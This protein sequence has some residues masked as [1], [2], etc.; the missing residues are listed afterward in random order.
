MIDTQV[1][2]KAR[3]AFFTPSEISVYLTQW[4]IRRP[5][6]VILEPSCGEAC[7]LLNAGDQLKRLGANAGAWRRQLH[8]I[9]IHKRSAETA[10]RI[11]TEHQFAATITVRNFFDV[12]PTA[13]Y[14]AIIGNPPYVRYQN[15]AGEA[16][17]KALEAALTQGV[18]LTGLTSSWAPFVVHASRFLKPTGRLALVLPA[19]LLAVNYAAQVRR[20]LLDRFSS[21]RLVL[22]ENRVFPGVLEEVVLLL[23]E[24]SGGA[25]NFEVYQARNLDDLSSTTAPAWTDYSPEGGDKWTPALLPSFA[26]GVYRKLTSGNSFADLL[27]WGETS[28]GS[29]T[30]NNEFFA[31]TRAEAT[32]LG[33]AEKELL[34]ISPPGSRHLKGLKFSDAG[35]EALAKD[36]ASCYLFHPSVDKPSS[37]AR[38]YISLGE[39]RGVQNAYKCENRTPWWRVPIVSVP[40]LLFTYMNHERPRLVTNEAGVRIINSVYGVSLKHTKKRLGRELLPISSLNSVT[41]LGAEV[42]GRAYGGGLLKMEPNEADL[43]PVP[44]TQLLTAAADDLRALRPQLATFLRGG[45]VQKIIELVDGVLLTQ[46]SSVSPEEIMALRS[47]RDYL[48]HR[49]RIRGG[50]QSGAS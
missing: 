11:L 40:D 39:K 28:L 29:V 13:T 15:F 49:R 19:E 47:A 8:G 32:K 35:W 44:S 25:K 42:V 2:R 1:L 6:D 45:H 34:R 36:G 43:L 3:G 50:G 38:R 21:V 24:G 22:F 10:S 20:F 27:S 33:L 46:H 7:F 48:F 4:A 5:E 30:G 23:A 37:A 16:R 12:V 41:L 26:F 17:A 18:R 31:L 14:D 9:E